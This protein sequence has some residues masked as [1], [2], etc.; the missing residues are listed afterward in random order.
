MG[1]KRNRTVGNKFE[2]ETAKKFREKVGWENVVTSRAESRIRDSE[3]VDLI[4][5]H[6][7][8]N[9]RM[10]YSIQNK[11]TTVNVNYHK[12]INEMTNLG[13]TIPVILHRKTEKKKDR[14]FRVG[15]YAILKMED[16]FSIITELEEFK[17]IKD[18]LE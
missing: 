3:K 12:I 13:D 10:L 9:G 17:R 11:C 7:A 16:F 15:E 1:G 14:F 18:V 4:N 8:I 6:E 5:K 2:V